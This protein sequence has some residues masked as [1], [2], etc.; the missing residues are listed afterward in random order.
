MAENEAPQESN[1][2]EIFRKV[3]KGVS[4]FCAA[5]LITIGV[6]GYVFFQMND[7][8]DIILP[9]YY[10]FFGVL[11]LIGEF[12]LTSLTVYFKFIESYFGRGVYYVLVGILCFHTDNIWNLIAGCFIILVGFVYMFFFCCF[13]KKSTTEEE[14]PVQTSEATTQSYGATP[15]PRV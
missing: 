11:I 9:A 8:I 4:I 10:V 14:K 2:V 7:P 12:Q 15:A 3:L 13:T 1:N 6:L 5:I